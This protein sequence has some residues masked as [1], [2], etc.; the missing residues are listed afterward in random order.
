MTIQ[1]EETFGPVIAVAPFDGSEEEAVKLS[2]ESTYG[3]TAS[4]YSCDLEKAKRVSRRI[5]VGQVGVNNNPIMNAASACP[6]VGHKGSG[7]G[8]HSGPDGWRQFSMPQSI[9]LTESP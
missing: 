3:L 4:V 6:W 8:S 1:K 9:V 2:N 5:K 7:F